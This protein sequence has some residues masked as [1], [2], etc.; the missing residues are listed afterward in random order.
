MMFIV[1]LVS[2]VI[3]VVLI[4]EYGDEPFPWEEDYESKKRQQE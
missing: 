4:N 3:G 1:S 2:I